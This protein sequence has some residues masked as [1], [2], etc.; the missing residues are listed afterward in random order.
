[1]VAGPS[2]SGKTSLLKFVI[3]L[4]LEKGEK[5]A[6]CKIDCLES[7]DEE[8]FKDLVPSAT[9]ISGDICPD[10]FLVSNLSELWAW[11][12]KKGASVLFIETAGLCHRCSPSTSKTISICALDA[13]AGIASPSRLGPMLRKADAVAVM[14]CDL[15]SQAEREILSFRLKNL[16]EKAKLF[17]VDGKAG[18]GAPLVASWILSLPPVESYENDKLRHT[19]PSGVCSY[20]VGE[21]RVGSDYQLGVVGKIDFEEN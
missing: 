18:Y 6:F 13:A 4:V 10:H 17:F 12:D 2:S 9:G 3:P 19:M 1:M 21:M 5:A 11:A 15:I 20:C 16:N 7:S 14:K 8:L